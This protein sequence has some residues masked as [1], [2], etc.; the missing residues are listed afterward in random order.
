ML[1]FRAFGFLECSKDKLYSK[2]VLKTG[3]LGV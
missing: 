3:K 1:N 2:K